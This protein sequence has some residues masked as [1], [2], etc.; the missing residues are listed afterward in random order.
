MYKGF[1]TI[2]NKKWKLTDIELI[3]RDLLNHFY[4]RKGERLMMPNF[5]SGL[6]ELTFEQM[7]PELREAIISD[8]TDIVT[9]D[10]RVSIESIDIVEYEHG[11]EIRMYL[12]FNT[13]DVS[14][15]MF[16]QFNT[17]TRQLT[18]I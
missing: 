10:P 1:S 8:A 17:S 13:L 9:S 4:T 16:L 6:W 5:G 3:K 2:D 12:L 7:T 14:D 18:H 15:Q 11:F